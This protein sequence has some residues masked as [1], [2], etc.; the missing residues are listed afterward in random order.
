MGWQPDS[1]GRYALFLGVLQKVVV[2]DRAAVVV[3][4]AFANPAVLD[5]TQLLLGAVL[6]SFQL[7]ADF[8]GIR[9]LCWA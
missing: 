1:P 2:A 9:T 6:Y 5:R 8:P 3:S 7:Y 4:A